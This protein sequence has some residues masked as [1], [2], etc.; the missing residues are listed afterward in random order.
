M[1]ISCFMRNWGTCDIWVI[2]LAQIL[3]VVGLNILAI[4]IYCI[5]CM[6]CIISNIVQYSDYY[7]N[8]E[9]LGFWPTVQYM[10]T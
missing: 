5:K 7:S 8:I 4:I 2:D 9:R 6:D 3:R 1:T 10:N